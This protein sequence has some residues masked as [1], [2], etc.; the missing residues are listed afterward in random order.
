MPSHM[1][2]RSDH[3]DVDAYRRNRYLERSRFEGEV[4]IETEFPKVREMADE[5]RNNAIFPS[6]L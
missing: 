5:M 6:V 1:K 2:W 3:F 4:A